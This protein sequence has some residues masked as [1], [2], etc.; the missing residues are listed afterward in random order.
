[1]LLLCCLLVTNSNLVVLLLCF[2][3]DT[4]SNLLV[5]LLCCLLITNSN[6]V[7]LLLCCLLVS[8]SN[9]LVLLFYCL[10]VIIENCIDWQAS[11]FVSSQT[12]LLGFSFVWPILEAHSSSHIYQ[13][14]HLDL[15]KQ[16]LFLPPSF[17]QTF[18]K[19][20]TKV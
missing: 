4:N 20:H 9:I 12:S 15:E 13:Q 10:L 16:T 14:V 7:V 18:L 6:I 1:M 5:M 8:H 11:Y 17:H 2:L 19:P 3:L